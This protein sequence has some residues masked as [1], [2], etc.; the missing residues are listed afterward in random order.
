MLEKFRALGFEAIIGLIL[1]F[2]FGYFVGWWTLPIA[3]AVAS[4]YLKSSVGKAFTAG[5]AAGTFLWVSF[6]GYL[7]FQNGGQLSGMLTETF[8]MPNGAMLATITG[9]L[10]GLL[11]GFGAMTGSLAREVIFPKNEK[12]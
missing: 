5:S 12:V 3:T 7:D 2:I 9:V 11:G 10:G 6:A 1:G 8:Q 4:F